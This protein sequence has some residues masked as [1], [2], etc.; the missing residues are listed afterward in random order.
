MALTSGRLFWVVLIG[1]VLAA[2]QSDTSP[3]P[4]FVSVDGS[5]STMTAEVSP[6]AT[7]DGN[8]VAAS[9]LE[10]PR[11]AQSSPSGASTQDQGYR[12][13][14][15][16]RSRYA[17]TYGHSYVVFG[18]ASRSGEM[19][20]PEVAGLHPKSYDA[21]PYTLGHFIPVA[22]ETGISDGDLEEPY[23]SASWRV[24][25]DEAK[26]QKAVAYIR[27]LQASSP[28]WNATVYNCNAFVA[29]IARSMG[30]KTPPIWLRPQQFMTKLREM[31][32][33]RG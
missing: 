33:A 6:T 10:A 24:M 1:L 23:R 17:L 26:Y 31:N 20:N 15:E 14:V 30:Y 7:R 25:V 13:F 12:Y 2:C 21:L 32:T 16:F 19:I 11:D 8:I 18:R 29:D 5:G 4:R 22:S 3:K 28:V 9:A 27:K